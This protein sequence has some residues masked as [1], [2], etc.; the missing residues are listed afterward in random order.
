MSFGYSIGD[1][2][3]ITQ[4]AWKTVQNAR[5]ACGEHD[6][7]TREVL[8]LHVVLRRL[9]Q[10]VEKPGNPINNGNP[11]DTY[12]EELM[13]IVD[14]CKKVLNVLDQVLTKYNALSEQERSG[15]KL[16]QKIRFGNGKMVDLADMRGKLIFYT[17]SMSLFLNIVSMGAMGRVERQ[18]NDAGGDLKDIKVAVNGI[19]AQLMSSSIRHEGSVLTAYADDDR[20]VWKEFRRELVEDGFSSSVI[21]KHKSLIKAYIEELG[22]RGVF[23]EVDPNDDAEERCCYAA[24]VVEGAMAYDP[25]SRSAPGASLRS[26]AE[27]EL[28]IESKTPPDFDTEPNA[29]SHSPAEPGHNEESIHQPASRA[30]DRARQLRE[31]GAR[32]QQEEEDS[33]LR[34]AAYHDRLR[35]LRDEQARRRVVSPTEPKAELRWIWLSN[36]SNEENQHFP[37]EEVVAPKT[38]HGSSTATTDGDHDGSNDACETPKTRFES[39]IESDGS[40]IE[41]DKTYSGSE[42]GLPRQMTRE[43]GKRDTKGFSRKSG[44]RPLGNGYDDSR[45]EYGDLQS[46]EANARDYLLKSREPRDTDLEQESPMKNGKRE[47][48]NVYDDFESRQADALLHILHSRSAGDFST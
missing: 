44:K 21:R 47:L 32:R 30:A 46:K 45:S 6:E 9:E 43:A 1:V 35:R 2:V 31:E 15:R 37:A 19:T 40:D 22:N 8:G 41:V 39:Y 27:V 18:M 5:K 20:A 38:K 34:R 28:P 11:D 33:E 13:V 26:E 23:D 25:E 4:L 10:E 17:S 42:Q 12:K 16:W 7:L 14:G 48:R 36:E 29:A 3:S 24:S